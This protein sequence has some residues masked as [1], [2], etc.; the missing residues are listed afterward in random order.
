MRKW[1]NLLLL[2]AIVSGVTF[3]AVQAQDSLPLY[4]VQEG[5]SLYSIAVRFGTSVD[6]L[7]TVNQI[8]DPS[9][10]F[11]GMELAVPGFEGFSG[12]LSTHVVRFGESLLGLATELNISID[13]IVKLNRILNPASLY[14]GQQL[15]IPVVTV[16][17]DVGSAELR[18]VIQPGDTLLGLAAQYRINPWLLSRATGKQEMLVMP[19]Q[20][21]QSTAANPI[22]GSSFISITVLPDA[23]LQGRTL[24]IEVEL[25]TGYLPAADLDGMRL[26]F[27]QAGTGRFVALQGIEALTEVGMQTLSICVQTEAD[28]SPVYSIQQSIEIVSGGYG[29]DPILYVSEES[30]DPETTAVETERVK[31]VVS[32]VTAERMWD[33]VFEFPTFFSESFPAVFG[34]RRNYNDQGYNSYHTGLDLYGNMTT[35]ILAP[36]NGVVVMV[37]ELPA[38]GLATYIDHGWGVFSGYGHQS[39]IFVQVGDRV[40]TGQLIGIVGASGR[41]TGPHLHWEIN[42]GGIAVDPIEWTQRVFPYSLSAE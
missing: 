14:A 2:V 19:G 13:D 31:A 35:E 39:E 23:V 29:Y 40:A 15:V 7:I 42:V 4:I 17:Q 18:N 1:F 27:N 20:L 6:E 16:E 37:E 8:V 24:E 22:A 3:T 11:P 5:D 41:V 34:S 36:A 12:Y 26:T 28:G 38:R 25:H 10:L 32:V 9:V 33:S 21:I 30:L